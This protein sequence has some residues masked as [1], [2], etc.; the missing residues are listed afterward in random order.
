M[1]S[2]IMIALGILMAIVFGFR[3]AN[4]LL[5]PGF[6]LREAYL[7]G[8]LFIAGWLVLA[9]L[10]ERRHAREHDPQDRT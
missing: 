10:K 7:F 8:G 1:K 4:A 3:A 2:H 9:G 6:G 5:E